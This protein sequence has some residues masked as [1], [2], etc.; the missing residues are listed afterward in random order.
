M[1]QPRDDQPTWQH[2]HDGTWQSFGDFSTVLELEFRTI[3]SNPSS[4]SGC[5]TVN[6]EQMVL[7]ANSEFV[8]RLTSKETPDIIFEWEDSSY[9]NRIWTSYNTDDCEAISI[10][11]LCG[12]SIVT[13]YVGL[14]NTPYEINFERRTQTNKMSNN[15]RW[16]RKV[17]PILFTASPTAMDPGAIAL[18]L[19]VRTFSTNDG[20]DKEYL[21]YDTFAPGWLTYTIKMIGNINNT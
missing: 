14:A 6:F 7:I 15:V 5:G 17:P 16:I 10:S 4:I 2:F 20:I 1:S 11:Q 8:R 13:I 9:G 19:Q 21:L 3:S 18:Q 12:R